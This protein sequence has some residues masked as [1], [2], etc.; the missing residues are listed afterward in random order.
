MFEIKIRE[1][2]YL[3]R[4]YIFLIIINSTA[5]CIYGTK[6][7]NADHQNSY[8]TDY[9]TNNGGDD[10]GEMQNT[11][12][13]EECKTLQYY[14]LKRKCS[15]LYPEDIK[16][17]YKD[18]LVESNDQYAVFSFNDE[19]VDNYFITFQHNALFHCEEIEVVDVVH[20]VCTNETGCSQDIVLKN[21]FMKCLEHKSNMVDELLVA[22]SPELHGSSSFTALHYSNFV[23]GKRSSNAH[24]TTVIQWWLRLGFVMLAII[25]C[26]REIFD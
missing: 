14:V 23:P 10:Y 21:G 12:L 24:L 20:F 22:C 3:Y 11:E 25:Y 19:G 17:T 6:L 18:D 2:K 4:T 5:K 9:Y 16:E 8:D 1:I 7:R 15:A 13:I 26:C